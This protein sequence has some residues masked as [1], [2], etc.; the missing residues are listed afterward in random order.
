MKTKILLSVLVLLALAIPALGQDAERVAEG[1]ARANISEYTGSFGFTRVLPEG[2]SQFVSGEFTMWLDG[3]LPYLVIDGVEVVAWGDEPLGGLPVNKLGSATGFW[4]NLR[5][6]DGVAG[7]DCAYGSA[8]DELLLPSDTISVELTLAYQEEFV[9]FD[10]NSY[11]V[12]PARLVLQL[13]GSSFSYDAQR[14]GFSIWFDPGVGGGYDIVDRSTGQVLVRGDIDDGLVE[15]NVVNVAM[16][17][18]VRELI[19]NGQSSVYWT[20]QWPACSIERD[21]QWQSAQVYTTRTFGQSLS[22]EVSGLQ[23]GGRLEVYSVDGDERVLIAITDAMTAPPMSIPVGKGGWPEG[24]LLQL[25]TPSGYDR[26]IVEVIGQPVGWNGFNV[27]AY[28][29]GGGLGKG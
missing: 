16:A 20:G 9:P 24:G 18:G 28:R 3:R 7:R 1:F 10:P 4:L 15:A 27:W 11:G 29:Y 19:P 12:D 26:L 17:G 2:T 13:G 8:Y 6:W 23:S 22:L 21:G 14:G 5:A 25:Q